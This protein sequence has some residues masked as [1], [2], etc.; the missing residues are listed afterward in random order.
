MHLFCNQKNNGQVIQADTVRLVA[1]EDKDAIHKIIKCLC[2]CNDCAKELTKTH[3]LAQHVK[4]LVLFNDM[5]TQGWKLLLCEPMISYFKAHS[6]PEEQNSGFVG[7]ILYAQGFLGKSEWHPRLKKVSFGTN[8]QS[9]FLQER[10]IYHENYCEALYLFL[11]HSA[12]QATRSLAK[13]LNTKFKMRRHGKRSTH[14]L[15][16]CVIILCRKFKFYV[17]EFYEIFYNMAEHSIADEC[18]D[19]LEALDLTERYL[20]KHKKTSSTYISKLVDFASVH[21]LRKIMTKPKKINKLL[22]I[23]LSTHRSQQ[24]TEN[25]A[26]DSLAADTGLEMNL[27]LIEKFREKLDTRGSSAREDGSCAEACANF[28]FILKQIIFCK[29]EYFRNNRDV[30]PECMFSK[31]SNE[32]YSYALRILGIFLQYNIEKKNVL[33]EEA[34]LL[35]RITSSQ[36]MQS[37]EM[38]SERAVDTVVTDLS[39]LYSAGYDII[40]SI[41]NIGVYIPMHTGSIKKYLELFGNNI[42]SAL[43]RKIVYNAILDENWEALVVYLQVKNMEDLAE[44]C[45]N[46][47]NMLQMVRQNKLQREPVA[48]ESGVIHQNKMKI[49]L[50]SAGAAR[51][52]VPNINIK[53][54]SKANS[55]LIKIVRR[56]GKPRTKR[57]IAFSTKKDASGEKEDN[58]SIESVN[59]SQQSC[60]NDV[61]NREP[62]R[63]KLFISAKTNK[64]DL[65]KPADSGENRKDQKNVQSANHT[66][67]VHAI[68]PV[69][70]AAP[71]E[72]IILENPRFAEIHYNSNFNKGNFN[73]GNISKPISVL[74]Q[75]QEPVARSGTVDPR[76][77][78]FVDIV[79]E[80]KGQESVLRNREFIQAFDTYNDYYRSY[81]VELIGEFRSV[82]EKCREAASPFK[83]CPQ[84]EITNGIMKILVPPAQLS[85]YDLLFF[86]ANQAGNQPSSTS[87]NNIKFHGMVVDLLNNHAFPN[88]HRSIA[89]LRI[90]ASVHFSTRN[91][92]LMVN[93][94]SMITCAR[95]WAALCNLKDNAIL[96]YILCSETKHAEDPL[97]GKAVLKPEI[98]RDG[99]QAICHLNNE[100]LLVVTR[101]LLS[102]AKFSLFQGPPGTGKTTVVIALI[103]LFLTQ[104]PFSKILLCTPSNAAIDELLHR[105][106]G[107]LFFAR[108]NHTIL[109]LGQASDPKLQKYTVDAIFSKMGGAITRQS[110]FSKASVICSTLSTSVCEN[111]NSLKFDLLIVDEA[112]QAT[113]MSTLIPLNHSV[114]KVV[115]I[116]D[117]KQLPP[118]VFSESLALERSLFERLSSFYHVHLLK[119]QYRMEYEICKIA[120]DLFYDGKLITPNS[121]KQE[122]ENIKR[123]LP[124]YKTY[125]VDIAC[126]R[127]QTDANKSFFNRAEAQVALELYSFFR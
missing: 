15:F 49:V 33:S 87:S 102:S 39:R 48:S 28:Q 37:V 9:F 111:L 22:A 52:P 82:M 53:S 24:R 68:I 107:N 57:L 91:S 58:K 99:Y 29:L 108:E 30:L 19:Y 89:I 100:Q 95:E 104:N 80:H 35:D 45:V 77:N 16:K 94:G 74:A 1:E 122:E 110:V 81:S 113:E 10:M 27:S 103:N 78:S 43:K 55:R 32:E 66:G 124:P 84:Y 101:I 25:A 71:T 34:F 125:F 20:L 92:L 109:R 61:G 88:E 65:E 69:K 75:S 90:P 44:I 8:E 38:F 41:E 60:A 13:L 72:T 2:S 96:P 126:G 123:K 86:E 42:S 40:T 17:C 62:G 54:E 23:I 73:K 14:F 117:P 46:K 79:V 51:I 76:P 47:R 114:D 26:D 18:T 127:Q 121:S 64:Q 31:R 106:I 36:A 7:L 5:A 115:L 11:V 83:E 118:T 59:C 98:V 67:T 63:F 12:I 119:T 93:A 50:H 120:S 85:K 70:R 112:C 116:G 97:G 56:A 21:D 6:T 3:G 105:L 4:K